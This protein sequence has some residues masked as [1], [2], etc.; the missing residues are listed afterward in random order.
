[1]AKSQEDGCWAAEKVSSNPALH[2]RQVVCLPGYD[3]SLVLGH[4]LWEKASALLDHEMG[5]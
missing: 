3:K 1:M 4:K 2:P 5:E